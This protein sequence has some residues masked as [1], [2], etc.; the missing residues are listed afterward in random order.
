MSAQLPRR[1]IV[2]DDNAVLARVV[3]DIIDSA[4]TLKY[5]G[6][7]QSGAEAVERARRGDADVFLLDLSLGD[8]A[9]FQV[10]ERM[11]AVS[12]NVKVII[13]TGHASP[14]LAEE[15]RRKGAVACITKDGAVG[16]L[17]DAIRSA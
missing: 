9:G 6:H 2:V 15:A 12:P 16:V 3:G 8:S 5:A 4:P 7:V 13:F 14:K 1:V 11:R 10:L 17:L